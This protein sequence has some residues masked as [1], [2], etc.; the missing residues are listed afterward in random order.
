MSLTGTLPPSE[1][2]LRTIGVLLF[3]VLGTVYLLQSESQLNIYSHLSRHQRVRPITVTSLHHQRE[4][5]HMTLGGWCEGHKWRRDWTTMHC[6]S[7]CC[8]AG[9][10]AGIRRPFGV[11]SPLSYCYPQFFSVKGSTLKR[12]SKRCVQWTDI[13]RLQGFTFC[14]SL[15]SEV[16]RDFPVLA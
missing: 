9:W 5:G 3:S 10:T 1:K 16:C 14:G 8:P 11:L 2:R 13:I 4:G 6:D 12:C 7:R 15:F